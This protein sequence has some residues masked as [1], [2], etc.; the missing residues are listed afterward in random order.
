[1]AWNPHISSAVRWT[2]HT[3]APCS[4]ESG[5]SGF[6]LSIS[7]SLHSIWVSRI[8]DITK[9]VNDSIGSHLETPQA[10]CLHTMVEVNVHPVAP[11]CPLHAAAHPAKMNMKDP[12]KKIPLQQWRQ[13]AVCQRSSGG[14]QSMCRGSSQFCLEE[15]LVLSRI[16]SMSRD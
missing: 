11:P 8:H 7:S 2:K 9:C 6:S 5:V 1:M 15:V 12:E 16:V 14:W 10:D 4:K 13:W 3:L